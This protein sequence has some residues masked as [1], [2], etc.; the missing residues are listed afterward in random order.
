[1][2]YEV[3]QL[4]HKTVLQKLP[5]LLLEL[6]YNRFLLFNMPLFQPSIS[7]QFDF[8]MSE[9]SARSYFLQRHSIAVPFFDFYSSYRFKMSAFKDSIYLSNKKKSRKTRSDE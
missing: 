1:M 8:S 5:I 3:R 2:R 9:S 7:V 6:F 4:N